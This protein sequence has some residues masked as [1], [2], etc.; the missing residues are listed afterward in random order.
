VPVWYESGA[1]PHPPHS[2]FGAY[3][4]RSQ[5][6]VAIIDLA[7]GDGYGLVAGKPMLGF[8]TRPAPEGEWGA[9][10]DDRQHFARTVWHRTGA[11][12]HARSWNDSEPTTS[13][14]C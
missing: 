11:S 13:L 1:Q 12:P 2:M 3:L 9:H 7:L 5:V 14:S 8:L 6:V 4:E 10:D